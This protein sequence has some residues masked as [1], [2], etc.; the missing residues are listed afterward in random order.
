MFIF[1]AIKIFVPTIVSFGFGMLIAPYVVRFLR[2]KKLWKKVNVK[3]ALGGGEATISSK[4]HNDEEKKIPR[5]GGTVVWLSVLF[6]SLVFWLLSNFLG[7]IP[8]LDFISRSQTWLPLFTM[9]VGALIGLVDDFAVTGTFGSYVGGGL[10]LKLRILLVSLMSLILGYWFYFKLGMSVIDIPFYGGLYIGI[11]IIPFMILTMVAIFSGG[12]IDG[13][14][15][16]SGSIMSSMFAAYGM[17]AVFN[18]QIDIA[19]FCFVVVGAILAF[20]WYNIPPAQFYMSETGMLA[21]TTS[22]TVVAFLTD[23]VMLLPIIAFPLFTASG[24]S[25]LQIASK[26]LRKGKKIFTVAPVHNHFQANGMAGYT[27]TMRYWIVSFMCALTGV[28]LHI[29]G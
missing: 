28:I 16:L 15:G 27:V 24:S 8:E 12:I 9:L 29:I 21:L 1:E 3:L 2:A 10:S 6:T 7:G 22:L 19:A 23:A 17:I 20:L 11:L 18:A 4:L 13:I 14:D 5:M 25:I 26:K